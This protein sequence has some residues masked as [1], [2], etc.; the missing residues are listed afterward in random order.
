MKRLPKNY[1]PLPVIALFIL[2]AL[3][4]GYFFGPAQ[5]PRHTVNRDSVR[6]DTNSQPAPPAPQ[7]PAV[8][9]SAQRILLIGDSMV[10]GL[11]HRLQDYAEANGHELKSVIW[12][13]SSTQWYGESDTLRYFIQQSQ[14]TFIIM[15]LGAN[16]LFIRNIAER[17]SGF[18]KE[19]IR[20]MDTI[21]FVWAGPPNWKDDTGIND[22]IETAVG[23][24]RFFLSARLSYER[25]SDGAHPTRQ[26]SAMWMDSI[27]HWIM[28]ESSYPILL[29]A[30]ST[31][32][33][34]PANRNVTVVHPYP[35][36]RPQPRETADTLP[37]ADSLVAAD[38]LAPIDTLSPA[39]NLSM[40]DSAA[41]NDTLAIPVDT[42]SVVRPTDTLSVNEPNP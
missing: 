38:S 35:E 1:Y 39:Q 10:A 23:P 36:A 3:L 21:P 15:V 28:H 6:T 40:T 27:A 24:G 42:L 33:K 18:V 41:V 11:M 4:A 20:Q 34:I 16:E 7:E 30:P 32:A 9:S 2:A 22:M 37:P 31:P 19:I 25:A 8:D 5:Y 26:S 13:T 17:R 29:D 14:P 12:Y